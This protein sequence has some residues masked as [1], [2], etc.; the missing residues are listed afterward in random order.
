MSV[1]FY[2]ELEMV[3]FA[4]EAAATKAALRAAQEAAAAGGEATGASAAAADGGGD[5]ERAIA[6]TSTT[7]MARW[8]IV[9]KWGGDEPAAQTQ[10]GGHRALVLAM[11]YG[12]DRSGVLHRG[13]DARRGRPAVRSPR[14]ARPPP[15]RNPFIEPPPPPNNDPVGTDLR[16]IPAVLKRLRD[17]WTRR[18]S[19]STG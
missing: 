11:R 16:E 1:A 2:P 15:A 7:C 6:S 12:V 10:H 8:S 4:P 13:H 18:A 5:A 3:L 17:D 14:E 9:M 19:R